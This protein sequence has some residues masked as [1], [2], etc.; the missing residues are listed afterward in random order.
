MSKRCPI[1][2][3][4]ASWLRRD[5]T[6]PTYARTLIRL[7][8]NAMR[9]G[10]RGLC[11][12][13]PRVMA[14]TMTKRRS[15]HP[16]PTVKM[17]MGGEGG[18]RRGARRRNQTQSD[19]S[20]FFHLNRR[21][22]ISRYGAGGTRGK[23]DTKDYDVAVMVLPTVISDALNKAKAATVAE[24]AGKGMHPSYRRRRHTSCAK[25][26]M[27]NKR[28]GTGWNYVCPAFSTLGITA[29]VPR[30]GHGYGSCRSVRCC[31]YAREPLA[32]NAGEMMV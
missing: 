20:T 28:K 26:R 16:A 5:V 4:R 29:V 7:R 6:S 14:R 25:R 8:A 31:R 1:H 24:R 22:M 11:R 19:R 27:R 9:L 15:W 21:R 23:G 32:A 18:R 13:L 12:A 17:M 3:S 30:M 2:G 10:R